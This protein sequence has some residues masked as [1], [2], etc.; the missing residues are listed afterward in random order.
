VSRYQR[1]KYWPGYKEVDKYVVLNEHDRDLTPVVLKLPKPPPERLIDGYDLHPDEQYFRRHEIPEKLIALERRANENVKKWA[2]RNVVHKVTGYKVLKEFWELFY[3]EKDSL[4]DEIEYIKKIHWHLY[5]GYWFYNDG[6]PTWIPPAHYRYLNFFYMKEAPYFVEYRDVDRKSEIYEWY[7]YNTHETFAKLGEKG[8]AISEPDGSYKMKKLGHRTIFGT[9]TPKRRRRGETQKSLN[10]GFWIQ[11]RHRGISLTVTSDIKDHSKKIFLEKMV[12][13]W[14]KYPLFLKPISYRDDPHKEISFSRP[15]GVY[16][17]NTLDSSFAFTESS[18]ERANDSRKLYYS[19]E[20]EEGKGASRADVSKRWEINKLTMCQG[21]IIH[22]YSNHPSTIEEMTEGGAVYQAMAKFSNFY[23][24]KPVS[25]QTM[26]GLLRMF[27]HGWDGMDGYIDRWGI[28]VIDTP[29]KR[30][31]ELAPPGALYPYSEKG[32]KQV[33]HEELEVYLKDGSVDAKNKYHE[34]LRKC[35]GNYADCWIGTFGDIG[36]DTVIIDTRLA[37]LRRQ[38]KTIQL[39]FKWKNDVRDSEVI[40]SDN[41]NGKFEV[42][43]LFLNEK[44]DNLKTLS[45]RIYDPTKGRIVPAYKPL[46]PS[47]FTAGAD[48]FDYSTRTEQQLREDKTRLS[49][50]SGA[51]FWEFDS[52]VDSS[53]NMAEWESYRFVCTYRHRAPS[54]AEYCEDMLMMCVYYGA[55]LVVENNKRNVIRHFIDRGYGGYLKYM[56]EPDGTFKREPGV[57]MGGPTKDEMLNLVRD[58]INDRGHKEC[59]AP[60]LED[61]KHIKGKEDLKNRDQLTSCGVALLGSKS[62]WGKEMERVSEA[63]LNLAGTSLAP[64]RYN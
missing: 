1:S 51:V 39:N 24:R 59:H 31:I 58:Y 25:G 22:G 46:Y 14:D 52:R 23:I 50:G 18:T 2:D 19:L 45:A 38:S 16:S 42:S 11:E 10:R 9:L 35:P 15:L 60:F 56:Q 48:P 21:H 29:T 40:R 12:P 32:A 28:S 61:C 41:P 3:K 43:N 6:K 13:A 33:W 57:W 53:D 5:Y 17:E 37:E 49:Y 34:V 47:R 30:Q 36:F 8:E 27:F 63:V 26:S 20:D 64:Q 44:I 54:E 55:M 7:C 62:S 4:K